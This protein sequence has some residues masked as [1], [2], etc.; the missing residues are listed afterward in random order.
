M[1]CRAD[2]NLWQNSKAHPKASVERRQTGKQAIPAD[3]YVLHYTITDEVVAKRLQR[4][5][6]RS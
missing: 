4:P 2:I 6:V 5:Y 1:N 3:S